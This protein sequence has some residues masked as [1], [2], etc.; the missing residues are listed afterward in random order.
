MYQIYVFMVGDGASVRKDF[1]AEITYGA[2]F[3]NVF[4]HNVFC[5]DRLEWKN[6]FTG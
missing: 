4:L 2:L 1:A 5:E 6:F 3:C